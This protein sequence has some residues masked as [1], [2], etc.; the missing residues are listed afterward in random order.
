M[1]IVTLSFTL[2]FF[3]FFG[4]PSFQSWEINCSC[5]FY[6]LKQK[7]KNKKKIVV[8][9]FINGRVRIMR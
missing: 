5:K 2:F 3:F 8:V 9:S 4:T 6:S 1:R 7:T